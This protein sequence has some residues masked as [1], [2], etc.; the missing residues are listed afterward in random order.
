MFEDKTLVCQDC[1]LEFIFSA[2]EQEFYQERALKMSPKRC[3]ECRINRRNSRNG[4]GP[5]EMFDAICARCG[6]DT[7]VPF[8]PVEGR[9]VYCMECFQQVRE[10]SSVIK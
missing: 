3:R 10:E 8:K 5:R 6:A 1:G 4:R 7:Q 2:G 9:P